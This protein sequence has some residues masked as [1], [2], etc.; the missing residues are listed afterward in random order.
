MALPH[1]LQI[2]LVLDADGFIWTWSEELKKKLNHV[3][4]KLFLSHFTTELCVRADGL[5]QTLS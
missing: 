3:V 4:I 5:N 1:S 2:K